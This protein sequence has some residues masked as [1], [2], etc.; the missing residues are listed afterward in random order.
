M[1]VQH[2]NDINHR[3]NQVDKLLGSYYEKNK[4]KNQFL[5]MIVIEKENSSYG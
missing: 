4:F 3:M 5:K 2:D 1:I